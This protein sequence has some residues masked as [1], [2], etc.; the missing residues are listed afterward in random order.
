MGV[1]RVHTGAIGCIGL[2]NYF[3]PL[4]AEHMYAINRSWELV[5]NTT[6]LLDLYPPTIF[7]HEAKLGIITAR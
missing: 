4:T 3:R 6:G 5:H 2:R 1:L 7:P